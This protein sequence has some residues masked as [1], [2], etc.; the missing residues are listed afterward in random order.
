ML[1]GLNY[2]NSLTIADDHAVADADNEILFGEGL[3]RDESFG[4]LGDVEYIG[5]CNVMV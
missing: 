3:G 2:W 4:E 5:N 1:F